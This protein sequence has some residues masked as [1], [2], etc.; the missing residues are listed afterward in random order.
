MFDKPFTLVCVVLGAMLWAARTDA[1]P[2]TD[3]DTEAPP[4]PVAPPVAEG[5]DQLTLPRGGLLLEAFL[6]MNLASGAVGKPFSLSPDLWYGATDEL[7]VGLVHSGVGASGFI[8]AAGNALC[9]TGTSGGCAKVYPGVGLD[10]RYKLPTKAGGFVWAADGGLY[11]LAVDPFQ[12]ALKLG[13]AGRWHAGSLAVE[14]A[15]NLLLGLTNRSPPAPAMG[16]VATPPNQEV[17]NIPVTGLY[18]VTPSIAL[19][20]QLGF[21]LPLENLGDAFAIPLS[22]GGHVQATDAITLNLA[23][24]LPFLVAGG[25]L[26]GFDA[27]TLTIG[28]AYAF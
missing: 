19:A 18:S 2:D 7:T 16:M 1:A 13:I 21:V 15:P 12:L 28:G 9:L 5:V 27:R 11:A 20:V 6:E 8:G 22:I 3:V 24:S 17:L 23:F 26:S 4:V 14:L 25:A 10:V